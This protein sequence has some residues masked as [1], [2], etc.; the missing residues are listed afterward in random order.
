MDGWQ[1]ELSV[2]ADPRDVEQA[3]SATGLSNAATLHVNHFIHWVLGRLI[4][5]LGLARAR[6]G[7]LDPLVG[8]VRD[9]IND[10]G[11]E[12]VEILSIPRPAGG[13]GII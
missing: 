11:H 12:L 9:G 10:I 4:S 2:I 5:T 7:L 1:T 3:N 13:A 8:C 6:L